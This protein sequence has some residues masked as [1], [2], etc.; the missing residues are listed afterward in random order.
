MSGVRIYPTR[1][2]LFFGFAK[3]GLSGFGG[4]LAFARQI[5]VEERRW[6]DDREFAE[7]LALGQVLPGPNVVNLSMFVGA[8]FHGPTGALAAVTGI[9]LPPICVIMLVAMVYDAI[10]QHPLVQSAIGAVAMA[11]AGLIVA[12]GAKIVARLT[13]RWPLALLAAAAFVGVAVFGLPLIW[14]VLA[15]SPVGIVIAWMLPE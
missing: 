2:D 10:G 14:I 7:M 12:M 11:A 15:L 9:L 5:M 1:R 8:R 3:M 4:V 6:L 13:W